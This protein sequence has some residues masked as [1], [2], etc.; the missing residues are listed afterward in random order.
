VSIDGKPV[1]T[2]SWREAG[3]VRVAVIHQDYRLVPFLTVQQN[4]LLGAELR[5][6]TGTRDTVVETLERVALS[7]TMVDRYPSTMSGGE[8][9]RV[10][11]A[12][13]LMA[14]APVIVADE[15]TGALDVDNTRR[16]TDILGQLGTVGGLTVLVATHDLS[17]AAGMGVQLELNSGRLEKALAA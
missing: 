11:I 17:V 4:L 8:Q 7:A 10:A 12:R 15:P 3:D 16:V 14:Q 5:G 13:A 6:V 9:Q 1:A 2:A